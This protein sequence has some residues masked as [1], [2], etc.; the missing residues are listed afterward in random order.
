VR[1]LRPM[2]PSSAIGGHGAAVHGYIAVVLVERGRE[3]V[4]AVAVAHEI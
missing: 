2:L 4:T 1:R 3:A